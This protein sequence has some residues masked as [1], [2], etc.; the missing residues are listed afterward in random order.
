MK[1]IIPIVAAM[2]AKKAAEA[3]PTAVGIDAPTRRA[4]IPVANPMLTPS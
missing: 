1:A 4:T 3:E 2:A